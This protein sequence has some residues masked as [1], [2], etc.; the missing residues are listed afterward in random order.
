[1]ARP[2]RI[3]VL[4]DPIASINP[5]KDSTL[6]MML[7]AQKRQVELLL[8]CELECVLAVTGLGD[9]QASHREPSGYGVK[10]LDFIVNDK[11]LDCLRHDPFSSSP[12]SL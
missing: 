8:P 6:G 2:V 12:R 5:A 3:A 11:K 4:M 7:A 1:M 10:E 9:L